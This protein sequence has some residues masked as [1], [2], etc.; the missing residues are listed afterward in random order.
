M[1]LFNVLKSKLSGSKA[2]YPSKAIHSLIL[3]GLLVTSVIL[4]VSAT[5]T[6]GSTVVHKVDGLYS[7]AIAPPS[8]TIAAG[9][10]EEMEFANSNYDI[11]NT[12]GKSINSG[13][14]ASLIGT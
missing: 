6:S 4:P 11:L 9:P 3:T 8:P 5:A 7:S 13:S 10:T 2:S 12:A 1:K 14:V